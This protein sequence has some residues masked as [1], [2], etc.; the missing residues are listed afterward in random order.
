MSFR[1]R[2][3]SSDD[4]QAI[5]EMAKLTGGGFTN[6]PPDRTT[7]L[8]K[9]T[10]SETA[11]ARAA[12]KPSDE[13][14]LFVL[15]NIET[16]QIR[17]TCQ[18]FGMVGIEH[19]FYSYRMST[20]TQT[21]KALGKTFRN[22][23]LTLVT[24]LEGCA[25]VGGLFLHP[26]E[27]AGGLGM[28]LARSR[29]LFMGLHRERFPDRILAELRGVIDEGGNAPFWEAIAGR[30]FGMSFQEAD[31]F[32]A[33]HGTQFIA[34]LM[35]KTPI[36]TS[37]LPESAKTVMGVPHPSG[38]AAMKMLESEGFRF[39]CYIDIFDGGPTMTAAIDQI[40]TIRESRKF[41]LADV[42]EDLAG[43]KMMVASGERTSFAACYGQIEDLGD[44]SAKLNRDAAGLLGIEPGAT[45][46]AMSR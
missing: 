22:E 44:G 5:Y 8:A 12:D 35:P 13:M 4:L 37:L 24:D 25:E 6:L 3:A 40:R 17:G 31:Q 28:L 21:S 23:A 30:F 20:L 33:T 26:G 38:R 18:V 7:L 46:L 11:L 16:R 27:R 39:E 41:Q 2:P 19:P 36:Y 29:Y 45:F 15:E 42:V 1:V 14:F 10:R 34:D 9:L 43:P 32:N